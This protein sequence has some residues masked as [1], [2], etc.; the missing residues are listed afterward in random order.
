MGTRK[1]NKKNPL[2]YAT[3]YLEKNKKF[4]INEKKYFEFKVRTNDYSD[5]AV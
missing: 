3:V 4:N 5:F 2:W 1:T